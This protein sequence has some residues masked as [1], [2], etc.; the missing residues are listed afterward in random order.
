MGGVYEI[1]GDTLN[2][3]LALKIIRQQYV[4]NATLRSRFTR[5]ARIQSALD[6]PGI[7]RVFELIEHDDNLAI[8]MEY[9]DA[10]TLRSMMKVKGLTPSMARNVLNDLLSA[11]MAAHDAGVV[12]RD[13]KPD[14]IFVITERTGRIRCKLIDFGIARQEAEEYTQLTGAQAFVGTYSYASPEQIE[15]S[16]TVDQRSDLYSLGVMLWEMLAGVS[17]YAHLNSAY[18]VQVAVVS[19]PLP[20]LP[21]DVPADLGR[22]VAELTRKDPAERPQTVEDVLQILEVPAQAL[23]NETLPGTVAGLT[24][25]PKREVPLPKTTTVTSSQSPSPAADVRPVERAPLTPP[26]APL[27][28]RLM[29]RAQDEI[30]PQLLVLTCIGIVAY[31][32]M[33][34]RRGTKRAQSISQALYRI[35]VYDTRTNEPAS[36]STVLHRNIIDM[37]VVQVPLLGVTSPLAW[38]LFPLPILSGMWLAVVL[39]IELLFAGFHP[40][41]RRLVDCLSHTRICREP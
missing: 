4:S 23:Q 21:S 5:E 18:S 2:N 31:P 29:A 9:V 36:Q 25:P 38:L 12:H 26:P 1:K 10:P 22:L 34:G 28:T 32:V 19:E 39:T 20:A 40:D 30:I 11:L 27:L 16:S 15:Q 37:I 14:N 3:R 17:P 7:A 13:I 33:M 41:K 35:R 6:H 8:V 24:E